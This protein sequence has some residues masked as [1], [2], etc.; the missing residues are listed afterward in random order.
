MQQ[1]RALINMSDN[2][3][4]DREAL[5]DR[6]RSART[7]GVVALQSYNLLRSKVSDGV[8]IALEGDDDPIYY[9]TTI[10]MI[11][12]NFSWTP[13]V[14]K[15]KDHVLGLRELLDRNLDAAEGKT[16]FIVDSD[17]DGLKGYAARDD[18][19]RTPS[20]SFENLI[21]SEDVLKQLLVGEFRCAPTSDEILTVSSCFQ[22]RL[23][24]FFTAMRL[25]NQALHYCGSKGL[26][27]GS[28][29]NK[30]GKYVKI[31]LEVVTQIY[32]AEDL[33]KLVGLPADVAVEEITEVS[34]RFDKLRPHEDWRGKY[35]IGFFV[36]FLAHLKEDRC[37]KSSALF[38]SR[39]STSFD[40]RSS[41]TRILS[42]IAQP[43]DCLRAFVAKMVA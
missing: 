18:T 13:L 21:V 36:E 11:E 15:G 33:T 40:P 9:A 32:T 39:K 35:L 25:A 2:N 4:K 16:F 28:V 37:N 31:N 19:Y 5:A 22:E 26:R 24:E 29:E 23:N 43:P 42:S 1:A 38:F 8:I 27:A 10:R 34:D 12:P 3:K 20:Y 6:M 41:T 14:C 30:I 17:F 7:R